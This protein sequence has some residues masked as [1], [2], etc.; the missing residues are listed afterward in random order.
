MSE[1]AASVPNWSTASFGDTTDTSPM[2]L[3]LLGEHLQLCRNARGR[4]FLTRC[5]AEAVQG[6]M[7][8]RI[9]TTLLVGG[10]LLL[11]LVA[12]IT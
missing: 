10:A 4:L 7:A 3:S 6:F 8:S 12:W 9:V 5:H 11:G 2:D 1:P